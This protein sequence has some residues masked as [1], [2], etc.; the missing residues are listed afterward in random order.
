V[1]KK[2]G[3]IAVYKHYEGSIKSIP[4]GSDLQPKL[5]NTMRT[6]FRKRHKE[7][8]LLRKQNYSR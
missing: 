2:Q 1:L 4:Q 8:T 6:W 7:W 5:L 3:T